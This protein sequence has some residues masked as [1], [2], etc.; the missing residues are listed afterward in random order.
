MII[1][2]EKRELFKEP[3]GSLINENDLKE[4]KGKLI[5]VGDVVS[6]TAHRIGIVPDI[7]VYDGMTERRTM[8]EFAELV[9]NENLRTIVVNNPAGTITK[10]LADAIKNALARNTKINIRVEGEEDLAVIPCILYSP[11][12]TNMIYGWPGKGMMLIVTDAHTKKRAISLLQEMEEH[13]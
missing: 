11:E 2:V 9:K 6:L 4:L 13:P 8:T 12:G 3:L 7:T 10:E 1:P 5:T